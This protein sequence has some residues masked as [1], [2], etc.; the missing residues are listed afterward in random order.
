MPPLTIRAARPDEQA[1][2]SDLVL[3]SKAAW[4]Y[5]AAFMALAA[6]A[7]A[8]RA[9]R[10]A[11]GLVLVAERAGTAVGVAVLAPAPAGEP[12]GTTELSHLFVAPEVL[13]RGVGGALM[14]AA[15]ALARARGAR[16]LRILADPHAAGFYARRGAALVGQAPSDAIPGR[17]LPLFVLPI[18]QGGETV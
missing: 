17:R 15:C 12:P 10:I 5:D 7:L 3:R 2:L 9:E 11:A 4:D 18:G 1:S 16:R 6:E 14:D 8:V 13:R